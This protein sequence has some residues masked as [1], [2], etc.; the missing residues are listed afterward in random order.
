MQPLVSESSRRRRRSV[1]ES[2]K[3]IFRSDDSH[4]AAAHPHSARRSVRGRRISEP[5]LPVGGLPT[6]ALVKPI[7]QPHRGVQTSHPSGLSRSGGVSDLLA[8]DS[9]PLRGDVP[10]RA[11]VQPNLR[12]PERSQSS[13][14]NSSPERARRTGIPIPHSTLP[15]RDLPLLGVV[16]PTLRLKRASPVD[17][18]ILSRRVGQR[19]PPIPNPTL[20]HGDLVLPDAIR[21]TVQAPEP[22]LTHPFALQEAGLRSSLRVDLAQ[23]REQPK[24]RP[25]GAILTAAV[26]TA[27]GRDRGDNPVQGNSKTRISQTPPGTSSSSVDS[28]HQTHLWQNI[29][30]DG[31]FKKLLQSHASRERFKDSLSRL[32]GNG[33]ALLDI[34]F[35]VKAQKAAQEYSEALLGEIR[36]MASKALGSEAAETGEMI[37]QFAFKK[38][39]SSELP[40]DIDIIIKDW[41]SSATIHDAINF[42]PPGSDTPT[43]SGLHLAASQGKFRD[44][45][46]SFSISDPREPTHPRRLTSKVSLDGE[47]LLPM[48][49]TSSDQHCTIHTA[50]STGGEPSSYSL[51]LT[52]PLLSQTTGK[53]RYLLTL[54]IDITQFVL[55]HVADTLLISTS[56]T[57]VQ[58]ELDMAITGAYREHMGSYSR[59]KATVQLD[60]A[61]R[62]GTP[63]EPKLL[64]KVSIATA[65]AEVPKTPATSGCLGALREDRREKRNMPEE[66]HPPQPATPAGEPQSAG[67]PGLVKEIK[68][69][70]GEFFTLS[71]LAENR[72]VY[73]ISYI[74]PALLAGGE[75]VTGHLTNTAPQVVRDIAAGLARYGT[76]TLTR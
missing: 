49:S 1:R 5:I 52:A 32:G 56:D 45:F 58:G 74:S 12:R 8:T 19:G 46:K 69:A 72:Q 43:F 7:P 31:V 63:G 27:H 54:H 13:N 71:P 44:L 17:P 41:F 26:E 61:F 3:Q 38:L 51:L 73:G 70:Y 15:Q 53:T 66:P 18:L 64:D 62:R 10:P 14:P 28:V 50:Y 4:D 20:P 40:R 9:I 24:K 35:A 11:T 60:N 47:S 29:Q 42:N 36:Q 76:L 23:T 21:P 55:S 2:L 34:W 67:F 16:R 39:L 48:T 68:S 75:Y 37:S 25:P 59:L 65:E 33:S 22:T 57:K 6:L 30:I